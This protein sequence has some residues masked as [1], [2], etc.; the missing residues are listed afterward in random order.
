MNLPSR[1]ASA[2][3]MASSSETVGVEAAIFAVKS[4]ISSST[5]C[6]RGKLNELGLT[7]ED[8][9]ARTYEMV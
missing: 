9:K 3:E 6:I 5:A 7:K 4:H 2:A 8:P 1:A